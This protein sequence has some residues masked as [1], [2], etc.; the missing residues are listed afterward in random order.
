M[1]R[2]CTVTAIA[3]A[4]LAV[5]A[6]ESD[7]SPTTPDAAPSFRT[8][9]S[10]AGPGALVTHGSGQFFSTFTAPGAPYFVAIGLTPRA[11]VEFCAGGD[12]ELAPSKAHFVE[13]QNGGVQTL[14]KSAGK[15][16][17]LLFPAGTED[18]CD[19]SPV[20][21][22][23]GVYT[24]NS[25]NVFGGNGRGTSGFR[26]R[27]QVTDQAGERLHVLVVVHSH[28]G[29]NGFEDIVRKIEVK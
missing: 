22:G 8:D 15:A 1:L 14:F 7:S 12:P 9:K 17:L 10:P 18:I 27:G 21:E 19:G 13:R 5:A 6:C 25:S 23:T 28:L 4:G 24:D 20:A 11:V 2:A 26:I 16:P 29:P 3:A